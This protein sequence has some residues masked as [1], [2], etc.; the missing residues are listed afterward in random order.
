[1][2]AMLPLAVV[3]LI[4]AF[5]GILAYIGS[6][7]YR[8]LF[9]PQYEA[10]LTVRGI[11][12]RLWAAV[13]ASGML[14][15]D[16]LW[17][18][19]NPKK[20]LE[21]T[22]VHNWDVVQDAMSEGKG[23]II[24]C[25]HLGGY[26]IIPR[27]LA[28]HY[29]ATIMYRPSRQEWLNEVVEEGRAYPNMHFVQT[30]LNGVRQMTRALSKGE[31]IA[32]L[33]DQVPSGGD[34]IWANFFGRPAYT[35]T[36]P[37]RLANRHNTPAVMFTAKRGILGGGWVIDAKRLDSFSDDPNIAVKELNT[38][39]EAAILVAPEQF[40]WSYNRYKHPAGAELPQAISYKIL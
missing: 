27:Y 38:A 28:N 37:I 6:K 34:G 14:F 25:P 4:G 8:S 2:I 29:P 17:I 39:I 31:V 13:R 20:A 18:W 1:M 40:I 35:T 30:N 16:S 15:S 19:R 32:I 11:P 21:I 22:T 5:L 9:R 36:L 26:E 12:F 24:L 23:M 7:K 10:A 33:P 3:Q